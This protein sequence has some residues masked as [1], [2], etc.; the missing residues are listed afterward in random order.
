MSILSAERNP[1]HRL[2]IEDQR[3]ELAAIL[4]AGNIA[5]MARMAVASAVLPSPKRVLSSEIYS[6]TQRAVPQEEA[7]HPS[8][9]AGLLGSALGNLC[10]GCRV[11]Q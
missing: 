4:A 9:Y 5:K 6:E 1:I 10:D 8:V 11:T 2:C 7:P 3:A